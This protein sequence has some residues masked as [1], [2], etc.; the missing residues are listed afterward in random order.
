VSAV[1]RE[2]P[3]RKR[4]DELGLDPHPLTPEQFDAL[5]KSEVEGWIGFVRKAGISKD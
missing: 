3:I 1:L 5:I 4:L 2:P